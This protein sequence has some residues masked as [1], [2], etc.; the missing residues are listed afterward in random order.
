MRRIKR[1]GKGNE[2]RLVCVGVGIEGVGGYDY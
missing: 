2:G 1:G